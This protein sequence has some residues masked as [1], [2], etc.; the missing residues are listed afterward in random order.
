M[1]SETE[2]RLRCLIRQNESPLHDPIFCVLPLRDSYRT[3]LLKL[4]FKSIESNHELYVI[5]ELAELLGE[6]MTSATMCKAADEPPSWCYTTYTYGEADAQGLAPQDLVDGLVVKQH[7]VAVAKAVVDFQSGSACV[8]DGLM[9]QH[10][11]YVAKA[12]V[13][14][15]SGSACNGDSAGGVGGGATASGGGGGGGASAAGT[16]RGLSENRADDRV[17]EVDG[18]GKCGAGYDEAC[19]PG[20]IPLH[21]PNN[22]FAAGGVCGG[23]TA[24]G[25]GGGATAAGTGRGLSENRADGGVSEVDGTGGC[26]AGCDERAAADTN[27]GGAVEAEQEAEAAPACLSGIITLH[28]SNNLLAGGTGC[29]AWE[30]GFLLAEFILGNPHLVADGVCDTLHNCQRNLTMNGIASEYVPS[31]DALHCY[32]KHDEG[33]QG[34]L[35]GSKAGMHGFHPTEHLESSAS[36]MQ[37]HELPWNDEGGQGCLRGSKAGMHGSHPT[38]HLGSSAS[39]MQVCELPWNDEDKACHLQPDVI[40]GSD[41]LYNRDCIPDLVGIIARLLRRTSTN[42]DARTSSTHYATCRPSTEENA[43][44]TTSRTHSATSGGPSKHQPSTDQDARTSSTH[45]AT[46]RPSTNQDARISRTH[47]AAFGG[48]GKH[49]PFTDQDAHTSRTHSATSG[50]PSNCRPSTQEN[51]RTSSSTPSATSGGPSTHRGH[52]PCAFLAS[53]VPTWQPCAYLASTV[54]T[55]ENLDYFLQHIEAHGL[56]LKDISQE[57]H[58]SRVHFYHAPDLVAQGTDRLVLHQITTAPY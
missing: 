27:G 50:G 20:I 17:R 57:A 39:V 11:V 48:P 21:Q 26:G 33:G 44:T 30:A 18:T 35:W 47:S 16:G 45:S 12:I 46:C 32:V 34:G 40:V 36:V 22:L 7:A 6:L 23:A 1:N 56:K 31:L 58:H 15:E 29:H 52:Q 37:V 38:E 14:F 55:E 53:A 54:R 10:A 8:D 4:L 25:G 3:R 28:Q 51:A 49:Q 2:W 41:L 42:Q 9:E 24:S 13:D 5:D 43:I 19:P